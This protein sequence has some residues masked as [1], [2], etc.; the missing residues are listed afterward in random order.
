MPSLQIAATV[1]GWFTVADGRLTV[2]VGPFAGGEDSGLLTRRTTNTTTNAIMTTASTPR[3]TRFVS[4]D[5][6]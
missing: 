1:G 4:L 5:I 2:A 3:T 6:D